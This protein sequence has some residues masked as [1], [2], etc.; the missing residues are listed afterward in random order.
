VRFVFFAPAAEL[1]ELEP[2]LQGLFILLR[3]IVD[4]VTGGAL[5][6]YQIILRHTRGNQIKVL[7][8]YQNLQTNARVPIG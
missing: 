4:P 1:T 5:H 7:E 6:F 2:V 8:F 3:I